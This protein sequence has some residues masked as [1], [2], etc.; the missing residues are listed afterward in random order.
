MQRLIDHYNRLI[1]STNLDKKRYLFYRINWSHRLIGITGPRGTGK[2]TLLLQH[3]KQEKM[4]ST[5]LYASL[6]NLYFAQHTLSDLAHEFYVN[7]GTHLFLDE[8]HR[9]ADWAVEIKNLY[10]SYPDLHIVFTGSSILEIYKAQADLSRR[11]VMYSL[12]GLSFREFLD[13]ENLVQ[14]PACSLE[15]VLSGHL[16][17]ASDIVAKMKVLPA[18]RNYLQYGY[19]PFYKEGIDVYYDR[20]TAIINVILENDLPAVVSLQHAT[21]LKIKRLLVHLSSLV[22]Y[23]PN[24]NDLSGLIETDRKSLLSYLQYLSRANLL[25]QFHSDNKRLSELAKPTKLYMDNSNLLFSLSGN[26]NSGTLRETFFANQLSQTHSLSIPV[27][28]DFQVDG[29]Y[30]FEVGGKGKTFQQIRNIENSYVAYDDME[31]GL[32]H[33][34][35]LWLFGLLY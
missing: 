12:S 33:K 34:I 27:T 20:L 32:G 16:E 11:S 35:P 29:R 26:T 19:Y 7:G 13:F 21:I 18:F 17:I 14:L 25:L 24:I 23:T 3:I 30:L 6:D 28:G 4:Q 8:V 2:T 31:I 1:V 15:D 9:Y 22:P 10:D 5:A